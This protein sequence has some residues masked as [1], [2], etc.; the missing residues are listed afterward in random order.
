NIGNVTGTKH[1]TVIEVCSSFVVS[2]PG[3]ASNSGAVFLFNSTPSGPENAA[4]ASYI[5][6]SPQDRVGYSLDAIPDIQQAVDSDGEPLYNIMTGAIGVNSNAGQVVILK[7]VPGSTT[8]DV[9]WSQT[10]QAGSS[11]GNSVA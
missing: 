4:A 3:Y 7:Y 9:V 11:F 10:G 1:P 6:A 8:L 5:G 2:S